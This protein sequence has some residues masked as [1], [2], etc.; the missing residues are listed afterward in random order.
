V[1]GRSKP[2]ELSGIHEIKK[3]A[4]LVCFYH[5]ISVENSREKA[6]DAAQLPASDSRIPRQH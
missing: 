1:E 3:D 2:L 6:T 5:A 4:S